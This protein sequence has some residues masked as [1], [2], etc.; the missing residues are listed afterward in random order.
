MAGIL[1]VFT[2]LYGPLAELLEK[3][4]RYQQK[5]KRGREV[6][7]QFANALENEIKNYQKLSENFEQSTKDNFI[8]ALLQL[9]EDPT[10]PQILKAIDSFSEMPKFF[11]EATKCFIR[12]A[13]ACNEISTKEA[14]MDSLRESSSFLYDFVGTMSKA[15]VA[16]DTVRID[17]N[18]FRFF[19]MYKKEMSETFDKTYGKIKLNRKDK[20]LIATLNKRATILTR[21]LEDHSFMRRHLRNKS[22]RKWKIG[23]VRIS[24][25]GKAVSMDRPSE[26]N[27]DILIPPQV[28]P[29]TT[30]L[31]EQS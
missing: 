30:F 8:P 17:G 5:R 2:G 1:G 10:P 19:N 4:R 12:L 27:M 24:W 21:K 23:F 28:R 9:D 13:R 25:V 20:E 7:D 26:F 16:K 6:Q 31:D 14:F 18:F 11:G 22:L 3:I 15:Y 29:F